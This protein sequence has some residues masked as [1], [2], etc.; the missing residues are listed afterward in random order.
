MG[1][2]LTRAQRSRRDRRKAKASHWAREGTA[3]PSAAGKTHHHYADPTYAPTAREL[4]QL[5]R[6]M[7]AGAQPR[8]D[9]VV[10]RLLSQELA[11]PAPATY[12]VAPLLR[13]AL[14]AAGLEL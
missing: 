5:R 7:R 1:S 14:E 8:L 6:A 10:A 3:R 2:R 13:A 12:S 4:A 11:A 9:D